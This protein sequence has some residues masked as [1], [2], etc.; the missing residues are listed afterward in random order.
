VYS[1]KLALSCCCQFKRLALSCGFKRANYR[2]RELLDCRY[3]HQ[4]HPQNN[5]VTY[6]GNLSFHQTTPAACPIYPTQSDGTSRAVGYAAGSAHGITYKG[7]LHGTYIPPCP[8]LAWASHPPARYAS[9]ASSSALTLAF[10]RSRFPPDW[11]MDP[12]LTVAA[13]GRYKAKTHTAQGLQPHT[14][15]WLSRLIRHAIPL[16][17]MNM[18]SDKDTRSIHCPSLH[19]LVQGM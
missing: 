6:T 12:S 19:E 2:R 8:Y 10:L 5:L 13:V 15:Q 14:A 4:E 7:N 16:S 1:T 3:R 17:V 11:N 18:T 9:A